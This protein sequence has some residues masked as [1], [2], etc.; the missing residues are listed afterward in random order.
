[1]IIGGLLAS[2][3]REIAKWHNE[4]R[5]HESMPEIIKAYSDPTPF[6]AED[7]K[8]LQDG[9]QSF[10]RRNQEASETGTWSREHARDHQGL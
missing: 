2:L 8:K 4:G 1:M 5:G 9:C 10:T 3:S 7:L 6:T